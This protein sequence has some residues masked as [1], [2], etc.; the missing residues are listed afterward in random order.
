MSKL[1]KKMQ[2]ATELGD[3]LENYASVANM[4]G[5]QF[6]ELFNEDATKAL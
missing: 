5:E 1:L 2:L 3:G 4:T 6:K